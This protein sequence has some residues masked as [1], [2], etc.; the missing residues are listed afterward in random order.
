MPSRM[1]VAFVITSVFLFKG[2]SNEICTFLKWFSQYIKVSESY[3]IKNMSDTS[4]TMILINIITSQLIELRL[5]Q[6]WLFYWT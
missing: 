1:L 4:G 3:D 6:K 5:D 2:F